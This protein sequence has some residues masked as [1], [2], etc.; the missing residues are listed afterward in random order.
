MKKTVTSSKR[1]EELLTRVNAGEQKTMR[2]WAADLFSDIEPEFGRTR[3]GQLM[4]KLRKQGHMLFPVPLKEG[5]AGIVTNVNDNPT[6]FAY[7][8]NRH[9]VKSV[10]N[11]LI[12]NADI[13]EKFIAHHPK[14]KPKIVDIFSSIV[15]TA[16][17]L[18]GQLTGIEY[19]APKK[20][21]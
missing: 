21:K 14:L 18:N 13:A 16:L 4:N 10:E 5:Q 11:N 20:L 7:V 12:R 9:S 19:K 6:A 2:Q 17:S 1:H 15:N 3:V 8:Y